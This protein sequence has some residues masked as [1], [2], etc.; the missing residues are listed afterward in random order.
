[1]KKQFL[2]G[3]M[4]MTL[5]L[6]SWAQS[7][8]LVITINGDQSVVYDGDNTNPNISVKFVSGDYSQDLVLNEDYTLSFGE[9][10]T[11]RNAGTYTATVTGLKTLSGKKNTKTFT[12][13]KK[14]LTSLTT[15]PG[16]IEYGTTVFDPSQF[17]ESIGTLSTNVEG[18]E[19]EKANALKCLYVQRVYKDGENEGEKEIAGNTYRVLVRAYA[20][21]NEKAKESNYYYVESAENLDA[22]MTI[23]KR[24]L[25]VAL[26]GENSRK[27]NGQTTELNTLNAT[28]TPGIAEGDNVTVSFTAAKGQTATN[29]SLLNA[30]TYTLTATLGGN[31]D[32]IKNYELVN[33]AS[34]ATYTI[35]RA[36]LEITAEK[37]E[38]TKV[39]SGTEE[40]GED[41]TSLYTFTMTPETGETVE[42]LG[43]KMIM[44]GTASSDGT[45]PNV[46]E[47]LVNPTVNGETIWMGTD[48]KGYSEPNLL[49]NYSLKYERNANKYEITPKEVKYWFT[50]DGKV[51]DAETVTAPEATLHVETD[52]FIGDDGFGDNEP[53][54]TFEAGKIVKNADTYKLVVADE[55][56]LQVANYTLVLDETEGYNEYVIRPAKASITVADQEV[57][58]NTP[59]TDEQL[60]EWNKNNDGTKISIEN[61]DDR[62]A[63]RK[64]IKLEIDE[65]VV[66]Y[67]VSDKYEN[68][69]KVVFVD[70]A[71]EEEVYKNYDFKYEDAFHYGT[72]TVKGFDEDHPLVLNV[73]NDFTEDVE[74]DEK[75]LAKIE[76]N[77]GATYKTVTIE[78][79]RSLNNA[80]YG[81]N[82]WYTLVLPF[83]VTVREISENFGYAIVNIPDGEK[84]NTNKDAIV[85][86][87]EMGKIPAHTPIAFKVD[88]DEDRAKNP[89]LTFTD[90]KIVAI[91][92]ADDWYTDNLKNKV[93]GTYAAK[94]ID[95]DYEFFL[96][97]STGNFYRASKWAGSHEGQ[98]MTIT[99]F[100]I[101]FDF[102]ANQTAA[103][104]IILEEADGS[105][106]AINAITGETITNN[107]EGWYS[108]DGMKLNAQPTQ[109]GVYINNGKKVVI[110]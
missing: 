35:E 81:E 55:S 89:T 48:G 1:M 26:D 86:K 60:A 46:G 38:L 2:L 34:A 83:D 64:L 90:K 32:D 99:P 57:D 21:D 100:N 4:A 3:L 41:L 47:Y 69:I 82:K 27:Y 85:F 17:V 8:D 50:S 36:T 73:N 20:K 58:Y 65:E 59:V 76:A 61:R 108:I 30:D 109:K 45:L 9:G 110:K 72:L 68:A 49:P 63:M 96:L 97:P 13:E 67:T 62:A 88:A 54:A 39:Y 5:P 31:A 33:A 6:T 104:R 28:L 102:S 24:Q 56:K 37:D 92:E 53:T 52:G 98:G 25:T 106:T 51:Y 79:L 16:Q 7:T 80:G 29:T 105:T 94:D 93:I 42:S 77:V 14:Q 66:N 43:L 40:N 107:A 84:Q 23:V 22:Q 44:T 71:E 18:D 74:D 11:V 91:P 101:Y 78:N 10:V 19:A 87:L 70:G 15:K 75:V 103:A 95:G 12:V